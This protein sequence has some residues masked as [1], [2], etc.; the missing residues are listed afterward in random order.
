MLSDAYQICNEIKMLVYRRLRDHM[1]D[2]DERDSYFSTIDLQV[3]N[4]F[5][6]LQ[7]LFVEELL[8][9]HQF[10]KQLNIGKN[11]WIMERVKNYIHEHYDQELKASELA[12]M[13]KVTPNY[14]SLIFKQETGKT[15]NEYLNE[16]RI[17]KAKELLV[18]TN[19]L[20]Y[21]IAER[22]GYK[23]YKYFSNLFKKNY[24]HRPIG[25]SG[26]Q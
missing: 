23:E 2:L 14:F 12:E 6:S 19:D 10:S 16:Y 26:F 11:R 25:I 7:Q 17:E 24:R 18:T 20:V 21:E 4:S 13:I 9:L 22:V 15:Y 5:A 8:A 3:Y 1:K